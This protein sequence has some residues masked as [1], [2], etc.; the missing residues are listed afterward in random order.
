MKN[1][2]EMREPSH[3][4]EGVYVIRVYIKPA[5]H[6]LFNVINFEFENAA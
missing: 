1:V 3:G 4:R 5:P 6:L 2:I